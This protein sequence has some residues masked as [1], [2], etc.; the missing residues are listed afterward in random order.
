[1][2][3]GSRRYIPSR[4]TYSRNDSAD[5][6]VAPV[7][8]TP[9]QAK[10]VRISASDVVFRRNVRWRTETFGARL[11]QPRRGRRYQWNLARSIET[12]AEYVLEKR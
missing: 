12:V 1:M 3:F 4:D 9:A 6:S 5:Q 11:R 8:P 10:S 2:E 7:S